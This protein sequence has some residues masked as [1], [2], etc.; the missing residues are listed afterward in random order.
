M[1][2][3]RSSNCKGSITSCSPWSPVNSHLQ[4][5]R[6]AAELTYHTGDAAKVVTPVRSHT[7]VDVVGAD[8]QHIYRTEARDELLHREGLSGSATPFEEARAS[9]AEEGFIPGARTAGGSATSLLGPGLRT[10][11]RRANR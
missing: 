5:D 4:P 10:P 9:M 6:V 8:D 2:L 7:S 1:A 3:A 11:S